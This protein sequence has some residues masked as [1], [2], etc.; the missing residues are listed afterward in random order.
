M[1]NRVPIR[2]K[3]TPEQIQNVLNELY[4]EA[5]SHVGMSAIFLQREARYHMPYIVT[6]ESVNKH[7][8]SLTYMCYNANGDY[9]GLSRLTLDFVKLFTGEQKIIYFNRHGVL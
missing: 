2:G 6:V 4:T 1:T 8:A 9:I 3:Y 5:L 7:N